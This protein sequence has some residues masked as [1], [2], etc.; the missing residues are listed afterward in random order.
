[1]TKVRK[2]EPPKNKGV[3]YTY[4]KK[5]NLRYIDKL[6]TNSGQTKSFCLDKIIDA[7]RR[8][9]L[10]LGI[11]DFEPKYVQKAKAYEES[12]KKKRSKKKAKRVS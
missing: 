3:C 1:M 4:L 6:S 10:D 5:V 8:E 7:V 2:K 9:N 12:L 11:K